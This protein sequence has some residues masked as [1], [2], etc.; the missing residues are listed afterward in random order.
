MN[1]Q[2]TIRTEPTLRR[3][4][5]QNGDYEDVYITDVPT[6][7]TKQGTA[8]NSVNMQYLD[9]TAT[10]TK[11]NVGADEYDVFSRN[12]TYDIGD[13]VI[14]NN[15]IYKCIVE[16]DTAGDF[17]SSDWQKYSINQMINEAKE[18]IEDINNNFLNKVYPIGSLYISINNTDPSTTIGGT[19]ERLKKVFPFAADD[20]DYQLGDTGGTETNTL[21]VA[22]L[23]SHNHNVP[24][25]SGT[26]SGSG[27]HD[28]SIPG[29]SAY[30]DGSGVY[31]ETWASKSQDRDG[32]TNSVGNHTHNFTT[33]QTDTSST[34]QGNEF[35][36][37]PPFMAMYM[38]IRT[39]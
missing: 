33:P 1:W 24:S 26:T 14:Y 36:N 7:V 19:W 25:M 21:T 35:N 10:N 32:R 9:D 4:T 23:P 11:T 8:L 20:E 30:N 27:A 5:K 28:H 22:N 13:I 18:E 37:M 3:I 31:V 2:D 17:N 15:I 6:N 29:T 12:E 34:G 16:I 39:A 38:W